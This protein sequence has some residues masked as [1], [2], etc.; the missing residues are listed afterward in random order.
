VRE[1]AQKQRILH[2][3]IVRLLL[4]ESGKKLICQRIVAPRERT[5]RIHEA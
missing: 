1:G 3:R 2:A 5:H 4:L